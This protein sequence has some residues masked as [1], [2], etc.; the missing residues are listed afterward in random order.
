M[1]VFYRHKNGEE[2]DTQNR[3]RFSMGSFIGLCRAYLHCLFRSLV[4]ALYAPR[5]L[6]VRLMYA[7]QGIEVDA[8]ELAEKA[9]EVIG[10]TTAMIVQQCSEDGLIFY[11][12]KEDALCLTDQYEFDRRMI[13]GYRSLSAMDQNLIYEAIVFLGTDFVDELEDEARQASFEA[14][15]IK[16]TS[17]Q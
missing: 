4:I 10:L 17:T 6:W 14:V 15:F 5:R 13:I 9:A 3:R 1:K 8:E 11:K 16:H 2:K 7:L 12:E